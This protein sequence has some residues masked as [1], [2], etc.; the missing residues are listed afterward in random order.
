[1][2]ATSVAGMTGLWHILRVDGFTPLEITFL[3][4]FGILFAWNSSSFWM[5][6]L[7][8]YATWRGSAQGA[9]RWPTDDDKS[10]RT[11]RARTAIVMPI[12]NEETDR[13]FASIAAIRASLIETGAGKKFDLFILSDSTKPEY[14]AGEKEAWRRMQ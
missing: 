2:L 7:G 3:T 12:Y 5:S 9:L 11:S 6:C 4:V 13:V 14:R 1:V 8:A 10:L